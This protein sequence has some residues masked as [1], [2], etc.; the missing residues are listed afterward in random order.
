MVG[1]GQVS[2]FHLASWAGV[3]G[4]AV[5]AIQNR[6]LKRA[7]TRASEYNIKSVYGD[8]A[9]MLDNEDLDAIDVTAGPAVHREACLQAA[10]RGIPVMCQKP[11]AGSLEAAR[12]LVAEIGDRIRVMV[13]ENW[14]FRPQYRL[15]GEWIRKGRIGR[16]RQFQFSCASSG[17]LRTADDSVPPLLRRQPFIAEM[18]RE[19]VLEVLIHHLDTIRFLLGR[20]LEVKA[21]VLRHRCPDI[22]GEDHASILLVGADG[23]VGTLVGDQCVPGAPTSMGDR[24]EIIGDQGRILFESDAATLISGGQSD[25]L[26]FDRQEAYLASYAGAVAH[27]AQCLR[28]GAPFETGAAD[29]L[30]TLELVEAVYQVAGRER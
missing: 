20:A 3:E 6:S 10:E 29:N 18:E 2:R 30:A 27:F 17:L 7:R 5:V 11:F 8:L 25:G 21:A 16:I 15:I 1:A 19:I 4:A 24:L 13:H 14:R 23:V 12:V 22:A 26:T 28:S 9:E